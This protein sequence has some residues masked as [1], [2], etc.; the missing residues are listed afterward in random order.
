MTRTS[1]RLGTTAGILL[2]CLVVGAL[3]IEPQLRVL[4]VTG[5]VERFDAFRAVAALAF[6]L[7]GLFV[8]AQ[9]P[10]S[11]VGWLMTAIGAAQGV[12]VAL[13]AYGLLG[14]NGGRLPGDDWAMWLSNWLWMPAYLAVPTLFLLVFPDGR[15]P[16]P[17]WR[18]VAVL[19]V[20]AIVVNTLDWALRPVTVVD[21]AGLY[22]P[23]YVGVLAGLPPFPPVLR[24]AAAGCSA[25]VAVLA[26]SSLAVRY[27]RAQPGARR[28][29]QWVL[30]AAL[31]TVVMLG[32][33]QLLQVAGPL[34]VALAPVPLPVAVAV[35][36]VAHR[37]WDL[38]LLLSRAL[39]FGAV[40]VL[41]LGAYALAV[42]TL[43]R[44]VGAA[45]SA[46]LVAFAVHPL[47]TRV[48]ARA[49]QL[50]YGDRD[51]PRQTLRRLGSRLSDAE[52][53]GRLLDRM[54]A[55][56]G[57]SLRVHY[58][59]VEESGAI[60]AQ[61]GRP[62][63]AS[64]RVPLHHSGERVGTLVIGERLRPR[65][66]ALLSEL[67]PHLAVAVRAHRL[68][69][70]LERSHR[71][72]LA[73]R[74]E[75]RDRLL[76]ELHDGLGPTLAALALHIDRGRGLI[77][78]DPGQAKHLLGDLALR[79]RTTVDTVRAIVHD[80]APPPLDDLGLADALAE[81]GRGFA[82]HLEVDVDTPPDLPDLP[83]AVEL[84]AY[85][86][87]AEALTNAARHAQASTCTIRL[88]AQDDLELRVDDNGI[89]M[90]SPTRHGF[91][92]T[93]MRRRAEELNGTFDLL[94]GTGPGTSVLVRLPL[95]GTP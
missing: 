36:V 66:H 35:A 31:V 52:P 38:D 17:R 73:A 43:G 51:D 9:L 10:V 23:G 30:A 4:G 93:S 82:G 69:A 86:I 84:A 21:V 39:A 50:V 12:G 67:A 88:R 89:G 94:T 77:D 91:G 53:P 63:E 27:R 65:D 24:V 61:W 41:L 42:F 75:E 45:A 78:T 55:E 60:V 79:T 37:L 3:A 18:P 83:A 28:Q 71:R 13:S 16:S 5:F 59:G 81:L 95:N 68:G 70:D 57:R 29:L 11:R 32:A 85:R 48:R 90:A 20:A 54:A 80:L 34:L 40:S 15:L 76:Y 62:A 49:N 58:V 44:V 8:V 92:L 25:A 74:Q 6:G 72:L 64:E 46:A 22:P 14:I 7:P 33:G 56:L 1:I 2:F 47:Y 87:T 19:A 26:V